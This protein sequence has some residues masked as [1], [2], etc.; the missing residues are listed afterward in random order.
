[1]TGDNEQATAAT[2][3]NKGTVTRSSWRTEVRVIPLSR[4]RP[5]D[6]VVEVRGIWN[7]W[8]IMVLGPTAVF[9]FYFFK[10]NCYGYHFEE[11]T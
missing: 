11:M 1:M 6:E 9:S 8:L 10:R 4:P 2:M 3:A 5:A 7:G